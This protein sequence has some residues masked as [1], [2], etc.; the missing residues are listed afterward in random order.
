MRHANLFEFRFDK[1]QRY[2]ILRMLNF[3]RSTV[4]YKNACCFISIKF[5]AEKSG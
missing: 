4:G 5:D 1:R 2:V 3:A